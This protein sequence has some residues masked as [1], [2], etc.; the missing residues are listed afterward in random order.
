MV[1]APTQPA[2]VATSPGGSA[3]GAITGPNTGT[4]GAAGSGHM[5]WWL[6]AGG[7]VLMLA[8]GSG[9]AYGTRH[10]R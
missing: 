5:F 8:G 6:F 7:I 9:V 3:G 10:R 1:P 4:G 2:A